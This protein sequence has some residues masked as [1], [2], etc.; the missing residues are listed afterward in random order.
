AGSPSLYLT[1]ALNSA[2]MIFTGGYH[3]R[4]HNGR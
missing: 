2:H 1:I 3:A 4:T